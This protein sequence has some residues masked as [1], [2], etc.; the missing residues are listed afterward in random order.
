MTAGGA[1]QPKLVPAPAVIG[2]SASEKRLLI[3]FF[4]HV[5]HHQ[6][7]PGSI[8]LHHHRHQPVVVFLKILP[9]ICGIKGFHHNPVFPAQIFQC[10]NIPAVVVD[11]ISRDSAHMLVGKYFHKLVQG[12]LIDLHIKGETGCSFRFS[13]LMRIHQK[14][15]GNVLIQKLPVFVQHPGIVVG[16]QNPVPAKLLGYGF[17]QGNIALLFIVQYGPP[18]ACVQQ[19]FYILH[20]LYVSGARYIHLRHGTDFFQKLQCGFVLFVSLG[21]IKYDQ[22]IHII[23]IVEL[24]QAQR[25]GFY[26]TGIRQTLYRMASVQ[27]NT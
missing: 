23:F 5:G 10:Q 1:F 14:Q 17:G 11:S 24:Y 15:A 22:F 27:I 2:H 26:H 12:N 20:M 7:L 16:G 19:F 8:I 9:P 18:A 25:I 4:I 3:G 13:D 21:H 6:N